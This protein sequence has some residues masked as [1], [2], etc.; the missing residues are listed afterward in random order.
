MEIKDKS[1][2]ALLNANRIG[3]GDI[4]PCVGVKTGALPEVHKPLLAENSDTGVSTRSVNPSTRT[5]EINNNKTIEKMQH[6]YAMRTTY[7]RERIAYDFIVS[8]GGTAF[9]PTLLKEKNING[10]KKLVEV[11]RIP[12]IFF[13]YG[14]EDEVKGY[15]YDNVHL[16]FLR[17]YYEQHIE[18]VRIIKKPLIVPDRQIQSLKILCNAEAEDI[19]IVPDEMTAKFK[20]GD[21]VVVIEG[22]F[23]G[24]EGHVAR[25]HGQQRVAIIIEGL[26]TIATAYIP[27]GHLE[28]T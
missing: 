22:E 19:R 18:G 1:C 5:N 12:N 26:C 11:S 23:K 2:T 17:F 28:K 21:S 27:S 15:A 3:G 10:K 6:W 13:V 14:T 25:W 4:P 16:P 7:G 20:E 9:L 8:I 24:I